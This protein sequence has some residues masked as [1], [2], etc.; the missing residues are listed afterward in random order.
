MSRA[1]FLAATAR[2]AAG[3][4]LSSDEVVLSWAVSRGVQPAAQQAPKRVSWAGE[5]SIATVREF[6][7]CDAPV[8]DQPETEPAH[9]FVSDILAGGVG[10]EDFGDSPSVPPRQL[11][12]GSSQPHRQPASPLE[13][14]WAPSGSL[15]QLEPEQLSVLRAEPMPC[16]NIPVATDPEDPPPR[17]VNPP[18]PFTTDQLIPR[19]TQRRVHQHGQLVKM[20][21]KRARGGGASSVH[22]ARRL[23][24]EALIL[25][26]REALNPCG[27]GYVWRRRANE[28]LWDVVQPSSYPDHKPDSSFNGE[29]FRDDALAL[30]MKDNQLVSWGLHGFPGARNM[31]TGTAVLGFPHA[32]ALKNASALADTQQ[33]DIDNG[34]VSHGEDFPQYWPCVCDPMNIVV[35]NGKPRATIDKTMRLSS[36]SHPQPVPSYNDFIDLEAERQELGRPFRLVR[37]WQFARG[38]AILA[39]AGVEVLIGK[40]DLSTYFRMHGKQRLHVWQSGRVLESLFGFDFRVNFG[41]RDAPD[42]TCRATDAICFFVRLELQRLE[43][44]YPSKCARIM[45]WLAMR[46]GLRDDQSSEHDFLWVVTYFFV[47]YVDDAALAAFNDLLYTQR[48]E[49]VMVTEVAKDGTVTTRQQRRAELYFA[50]SMGIAQRYGHDT[51]EKKQVKMNLNLEFLGVQLSITEWRRHL[52]AEKSKSYRGALQH[53]ITTGKV[54]PSG[55]LSVAREP[56]NSL[57]H[58]LLSASECIPLGRPHLF[59]LREAIKADNALR[60]SAVIIGNKAAAELAWWDHQLLHADES[61]LPLASRYSFPSSSDDTIVHYADASREPGEQSASGAG[62]WSVIAGTFVYVEWRWTPHEVQRFSVNVLET[63]VKDVSGRCF[64]AYARQQGLAATHSLAFTD[65]STA[66][67]IAERGRAST[68]AL[69]QLNAQR[70]QWL[71]DS[72]V[73]QRSERVAS[74]DNDV[75]DLLSR[76]DIEEALRFPRDASL[77]VRRIDV[78]AV[79]RDTSHLAPTWA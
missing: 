60:S 17:F 29:R 38:A 74:A 68:E 41:E 58:K 9:S 76:N 10:D 70:T 24:P 63:I 3:T 7:V 62:A 15:R 77:P 39:T 21:I 54:L 18:G 61:G 42:H 23:R 73:H 72:G 36:S 71:V 20:C 25:V 75:A 22:V 50:A 6:T 40:F 33:R 30:G 32:G 1:S 47:Y 26:E 45:E 44:E 37:V 79:D 46:L 53:M 59:H 69:N 55:S 67:H 34:F 48:G 35:Q 28:D 4:P 11:H 65:N 2:Q 16:V 13:Q 49:P 43:R 12:V 51:P 19:D 56:C 64:I 14:R 31:P 27:F 78:L 5:Q 8:V 52:T 57:L 66:E